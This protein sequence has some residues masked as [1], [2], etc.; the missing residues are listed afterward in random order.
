[1]KPDLSIKSEVTNLPATSIA[2]AAASEE[3]IKSS[4]PDPVVKSEETDSHAASA[5]ELSDPEETINVHRG[6]EDHV[7]APPSL[8]KIYDLAIESM[9]RI[10]PCALHPFNRY[11]ETARSP[12]PENFTFL[13]G[14]GTAASP[15]RVDTPL[16]AGVELQRCWPVAVG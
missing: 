13:S 6:V 14:N 9:A 8:N 2:K 3:T 7:H 11:L 4:A 1:M 10:S 16:P 5:A 15:I 12:L